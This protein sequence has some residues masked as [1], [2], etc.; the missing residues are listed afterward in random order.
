MKP[1]VLNAVH[2]LQSEPPFGAV[3]MKLPDAAIEKIWYA[4]LMG[5]YRRTRNRTCPS[6]GIMMPNT[7][8]C[9]DCE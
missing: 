3:R 6:C 7:G 5:G 8:R 2:E 1:Y 4:K 9:D